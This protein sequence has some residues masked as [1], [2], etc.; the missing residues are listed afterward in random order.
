M[1]DSKAETVVEELPGDKM[2]VHFEAKARKQRAFRCY[3]RT[4]R[5]LEDMESILRDAWASISCIR[6][7]IQEQTAVMTSSAEIFEV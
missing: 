2:L 7:L 5:E 3:T 6:G 4:L 1:A